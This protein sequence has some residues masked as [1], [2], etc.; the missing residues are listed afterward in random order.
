MRM[1]A[2]PP[3]LSVVI[4]DD[5]IKRNAYELWTRFD[6]PGSKVIKNR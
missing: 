1:Q 2:M 4:R 6:I 5:R 3:V